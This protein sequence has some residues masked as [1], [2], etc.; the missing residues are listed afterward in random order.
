M[1]SILESSTQELG[2]ASDAVS[3]KVAVAVEMMQSK[4]SEM[5]GQAADAVNEIG[6]ASE[7]MDF[8]SR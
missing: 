7:M 4:S 8:R 5:K 2:K 1:S 6:V 3:D